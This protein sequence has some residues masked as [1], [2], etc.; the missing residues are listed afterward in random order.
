MNAAHR[1]RRP[2]EQPV[3][4]LTKVER[5]AALKA[6]AGDQIDFTGDV[7]VHDIVCCCGL[8]IEQVKAAVGQLRARATT[9]GTEVQTDFLMSGTCD[10]PD[11]VTTKNDNG[12]K[13]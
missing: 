5:Y 4:P 13:Q 8:P 9:S 12:V 2:P 6:A 1:W 10:V 11:A 7:D 3:D